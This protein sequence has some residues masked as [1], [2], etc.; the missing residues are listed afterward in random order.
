MN[1][2]IKIETS[3]S[4]ITILTTGIQG[5]AGAKGEK[6]DAGDFDGQIII[7]MQ[8]KVEDLSESFTELETSVSDRLAQ[9]ISSAEVD[10]KITTKA[11]LV[12]GLIPSNQLPSFV[13]DVVEFDTLNNF[14]SIG[15][16]GKI[17]VSKN[18][19]KTYR[20]SGTTYASLDDGITLGTT[21]NTAAR[22]DQG[23]I[24]FEHTS[25]TGNP[26]NTTTKDI[27][28]DT[29][30]FFTENRVLKTLLSG[31]SDQ[32]NAEILP[33]DNLITALGKLQQQLKNVSPATTN[34]I[35]LKD[36]TGISWGYFVDVNNTELYIAVIGDQ[37]WLRG[38]LVLNA[39]GYG[40]Y[41]V[42]FSLPKKTYNL[43]GI[44]ANNFLSK[45]INFGVNTTIGNTI[46]TLPVYVGA[47]SSDQNYWSLI[48][49]SGDFA[50]EGYLPATCIAT[51]V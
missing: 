50:T 34:W 10:Q 44:K 2:I 11:D 19:N 49:T 27:T 30:L 13:D 37:L 46:K 17:Y 26:H 15:E 36:I 43:Q 18:T 48:M 6:G 25:K 41:N 38:Y 5:V 22:G 32:L 39:T 20:W 9:K 35:N 14:P 47:S 45:P 40:V 16:S 51:L 23:K 8:N 1:D 24:A 12:N 33:T 28:E 21:E 3:R 4:K 31:L 29:N 42:V 7:E